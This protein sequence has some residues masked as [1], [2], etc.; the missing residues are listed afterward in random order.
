VGPQSAALRVT[1]TKRL[2]F[3]LSNPHLLLDTL[4]HENGRFLLEYSVAFKESAPPARVLLRGIFEAKNAEDGF[5]AASRSVLGDHTFLR[6]S[7][8]VAIVAPER[9]VCL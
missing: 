2:N 6:C 4:G 1:P 5:G 3:R 8:Q 9:S 7:N